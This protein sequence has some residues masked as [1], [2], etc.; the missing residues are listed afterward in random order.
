MK[1]GKLGKLHTNISLTFP[2]AYDLAVHSSFPSDISSQPRSVIRTLGIEWMEMALKLYDDEA[3]RDDQL[4][5][6]SNE[7]LGEMVKS[8]SLGLV[9]NFTY[10][11]SSLFYDLNSSTMKLGLQIVIIT[12]NITSII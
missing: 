10:V 7:L 11:L 12:T 9:S 2:H 6:R 5:G 4:K 8:V 3:V 1:D